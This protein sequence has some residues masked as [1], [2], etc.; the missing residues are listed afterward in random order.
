MKKLFIV[1]ALV[2]LSATTFAQSIKYMRANSLQIGTRSNTKQDFVWE[3]DTRPVDIL[4]QIES[5]KL[6]I[7][8]KVSQVYRVISLMKEETNSSKWYC[9]DATG[10]NCYLYIINNA[11]AGDVI[12]GIEYSDAVWYYVG[13]ME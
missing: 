8:S 11:N 3:K 10:T 4:I 5:S 7:Y 6:T 12:V 13:K 1:I 9:A 2:L